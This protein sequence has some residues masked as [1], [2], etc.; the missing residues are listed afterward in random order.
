[1]LS[2]KEVK[3]GIVV[4][5]LFPLATTT[6][7]DW[8]RK[9]IQETF[10]LC[11]PLAKKC[12]GSFKG[13]TPYFVKWLSP[14]NFPSFMTINDQLIFTNWV[15]SIINALTPFLPRGSFSW[16]PEEEEKEF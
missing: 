7:S 12:V 5:E 8:R 9:N 16:S 15:I 13:A 4:D 2:C 14:G 11:P 6:S 3:R 10:L 1:M